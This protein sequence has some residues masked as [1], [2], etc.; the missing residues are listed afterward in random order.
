MA[1]PVPELNWHYP[2]ADLAKRY[3]D[4][5]ASGLSASCVLFA[6]RRKGKTEFVQEDLAPYA[7]Q[8]GYR[9]VY[10]SMWLNRENPA[11]ALVQ[12]LLKAA[13]P[14]GIAELIKGKLRQPL[15]SA[16]ISLDLPAVGKIHAHADFAEED[17]RANSEM[18]LAAAMDAVI[19]AAG[20]NKVLL[21]LDEI[22]TLGDPSFKNF[23]ATLRTVLDARKARVKV[24][25][26]GSSR[27]RLQ[28]MFFRTKA[29]LFQFSNPSDFPDLGIEFV[30]HLILKFHEL[31]GRPLNKTE[32]LKA[33]LA[34]GQTPGHIKEALLKLVRNGG[35][36]IMTATYVVIS[37]SQRTS[38]YK[39]RMASLN[40]LDRAV[41]FTVLHGADPMSVPARRAIGQEMGRAEI[42]VDKLQRSLERLLEEKILYQRRPGQYMIE[43]HQLAAYLSRD[44]A[45]EVSVPADGSREE[46]AAEA[47]RM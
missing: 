24:V 3:L 43:D 7:E 46:D 20:K 13:Q 19:K 42:P 35:T 32:A 45:D 10:C 16:E 4:T 21:L 2:R 25:F 12:T 47:P 8:N 26:T 23:I 15:K 1:K 39:E 41:V 40:A 28:E 38:G 34:T 30:D 22:Q 31:T 5:F 6:P 44:E 17:Q 33:F 29:P 37:E 27:H 11:G 36:D 18:Q 9:A 14:R